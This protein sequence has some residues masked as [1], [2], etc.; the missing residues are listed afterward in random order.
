M[1][2]QQLLNPNLWAAK[3]ADDLF[4]YAMTKSSGV[5]QAEDF[6]QEKLLPALSALS[7]FKGNSSERICLLFLPGVWLVPLFKHKENG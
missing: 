5:E 2:E 4:G 7:N 6:V 1:A 3:Y